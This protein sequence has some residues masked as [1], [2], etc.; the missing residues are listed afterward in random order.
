LVSLNCLTDRIMSVSAAVLQIPMYSEFP[1]NNKMLAFANLV[2]WTF[3]FLLAQNLPKT[4]IPTDAQLSL[5]KNHEYPTTWL[6]SRTR[7][8][9]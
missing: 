4:T 2:S 1:L 5:D 7:S 8:G 3:M 9:L 6:C